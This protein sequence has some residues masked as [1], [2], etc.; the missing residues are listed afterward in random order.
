M[1]RD[2]EKTPFQSWAVD[3]IIDRP[4]YFPEQL[5]LSLSN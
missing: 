2:K 5:N 1:E 3:L 4:F